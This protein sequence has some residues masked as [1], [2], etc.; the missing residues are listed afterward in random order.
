MDMKASG[1]IK[2]MFRMNNL[3][4][5]HAFS[6]ASILLF[7]IGIFL[8]AIGYYQSQNSF[9]F[10]CY[11]L[12]LLVLLTSEYLFLSKSKNWAPISIVCYCVLVLN[13]TV[14]NVY[15]VLYLE[16]PAVDIY[17]A[18]LIGLAIIIT[19][20]FVLVP[21][22]PM[23]FSLIIS[24]TYVFVSLYSNNELFNKDL[25]I[26]P[27]INIGI[28][29]AF[30]T[31]MRLF[32]KSEDKS[33]KLLGLVNLEKDKVKKSILLLTQKAKEPNI[34]ISEDIERI[35]NTMNFYLPEVILEYTDKLTSDENLFFNR[36]LKKHPDLSSNELKLCY[37]LVENMSSKEIAKATNCTT[38]SV[39]VFR[40]RLRKKLALRA[41][42]NLVS[43][44][45]TF[46][47]EQ[48]KIIRK[49][50]GIRY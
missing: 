38:N 35:F 18:S 33:N 48:Q 12:V 23:I 25:I 45:K 7:S 49:R 20:V 39:K 24:A 13:L 3:K 1:R 19:S 50:K 16:H 32:R 28:A 42:A 9:L 4:S 14:T 30:I 10:L 37:M 8:D 44:L 29:Y 47:M 34:D 15:N 11:I 6:T 31:F 27:M 17:R 40:S 2:S 26:I 43:Y 41:K 36:I 21:R 22:W 5:G 46:E